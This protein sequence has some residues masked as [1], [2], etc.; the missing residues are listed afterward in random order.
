M[1][2]KKLSKSE[3]TYVKNMAEKYKYDYDVA[4]KKFHRAI[5][6]AEKN[7]PENVFA[8]AKKIFE[9]DLRKKNDIEE[10]I[11]TT[12]AGVNPGGSG[13]YKQ[14]F[15]RDAIS[16]QYKEDEKQREK[17]MKSGSAAVKYLKQSLN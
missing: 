17:A 13:E 6:N 4:V 3:E 15:G 9:G 10:K 11:T 2:N 5:K 7:K 1:P 12:V 14:R 8:L 16:K